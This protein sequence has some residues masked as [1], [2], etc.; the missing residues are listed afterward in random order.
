MESI[1]ILCE[2]I[3]FEYDEKYLF[4]YDEWYL[5]LE[6]VPPSMV[7]EGCHSEKKNKQQTNKEK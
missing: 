3:T 1:A 6:L 7:A 5:F 2:I 4:E